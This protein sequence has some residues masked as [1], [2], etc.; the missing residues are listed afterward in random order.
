MAD[1]HKEHLPA[2]LRGVW[3]RDYIKQTFRA[4]KPIGL[5]PAMIVELLVDL[6]KVPSTNFPRFKRPWNGEVYSNWAIHKERTP[7]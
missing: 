1:Q 2:W 5:F 6:L 4:P 3:S 7:H